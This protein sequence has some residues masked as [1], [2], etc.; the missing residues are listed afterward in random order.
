MPLQNQDAINDLA[1]KIARHIDAMPSDNPQGPT[2]EEKDTL[3]GAVMVV[4]NLAFSFDRI[5]DACERIAQALEDE[6]KIHHPQ[7]PKS[8]YPILRTCSVCGLALPRGNC[9]MAECPQAL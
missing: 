7:T 1:L 4:A 5:A 9:G 8:E 3:K 2:P 6:H